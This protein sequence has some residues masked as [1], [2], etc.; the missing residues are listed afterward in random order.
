MSERD[1]FIEAREKFITSRP[2]CLNELLL[3]VEGRKLDPKT[4]AE[5]IAQPE[6]ATVERDYGGDI[7]QCQ[8]PGCDRMGAINRDRGVIRSIGYAAHGPCFAQA[9][10]EENAKALKRWGESKKF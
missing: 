3:L 4:D 5:L 2:I 1:D 9:I 7:L 10:G 8:F 6:V